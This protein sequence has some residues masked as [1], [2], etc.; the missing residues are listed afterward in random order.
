MIIDDL[1]VLER[2]VRREF[3]A[4]EDGCLTDSDLRLNKVLDEYKIAGLEVNLKKEF[5]NQLQARFWGIELD[6]DKGIIRA[7]SLRLWPLVMITTRVAMLGLCSVSLMEALAGSWI[8]VFMTR[9]RFMC[10]LNLVF[11]SLGV[12]DQRAIIRLSPALVSELWTLSL[13]GPLAATNLRAQYHHELVATDSSLDFMAGV[14]APIPPIVAE[15]VGKRSLKRGIWSK[16][17]SGD[18]EWRHSHGMLDVDRQV[19]DEAYRSHPLMEMLAR[20]LPYREQWR[21][22]IHKRKHINVTELTAH[23]YA[24]R[25][26]ASNI[27]HARVLFGLDSQVSLGATVKG[28]ASSVALNEQLQKALPWA[29]GADIYTVCTFTFHLNI[30]GLMLRLEIEKSKA[31][32]CRCL[33]GGKMH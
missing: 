4:R 8:S 29:I 33:I 31:Q 2:I 25:R 11:E 19:P 1:V 26:L 12:E 30:T 17:L 10:C 9:R 14:A 24:E 32:I 5:R 20:A 21:R 7:S 28:R 27:R 18:A 6:G 16:L 23:L 13:L 3:F 15:E 22:K